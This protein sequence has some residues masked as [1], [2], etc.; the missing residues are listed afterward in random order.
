MTNPNRKIRIIK[1]TINIGCGE[2]GE[3]L[4]RAKKL[5]EQLINKKAVVTTTHG[6][7]TFGMA[8]GRPIGVKITLRGEAAK[9]FLKKALSARDAKL[10]SRCF[11]EQ[12][13]FA[14]GVREHIDL[15]GVRYDPDIGIFG[16]D[17]CVT[18]ERPGFSISRARIPR[19]VGHAHR[20]S[21]EE[22][23]EWAIA[24]LGV[25]VE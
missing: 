13:N 18:L 14:F 6:R 20:I 24:N 2:S 25:K 16:M 17:V 5:I 7:T 21:S 8:K 10:P 1:V 4:E 23:R 9:D 12:G 11:D 3:K 22:A 19:C 15:P